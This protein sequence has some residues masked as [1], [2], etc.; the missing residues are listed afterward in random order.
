MPGSLEEKPFFAKS[1]GLN[2]SEPVED[3]EHLSVLEDSGAVVGWRRL[4][5]YVVLVGASFVQ[6]GTPSGMLMEAGPC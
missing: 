4:R 3:A 6:L 1:G 2:I 5:R